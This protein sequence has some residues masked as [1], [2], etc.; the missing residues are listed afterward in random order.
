MKDTFK[1]INK[2]SEEILFKD[3]NSKFFG[4]AFPV[5]SEDKV[6]QYIEDLK[7]QHHQARHWCYAYQIGTDETNIQFRA[8]DDG[9]PN[10][11]AG[12]P[13]YGQ[14]QSFEVT[15]ILIVVVRYFGGVKLGVSGLI[16]AYKTAAQL[17]L[18]ASKI[19]TKTINR[20]YKI[21]FDYKNMNKVMRIIKEK[22]IKVLDQK[23]ELDCQL[24]ISVRLK[25]SES[26]FNAF[27]SLFEVSI[28]PLND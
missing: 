9:E 8:N 20:H 16:N 2:P 24:N 13:I 3:K 19:V 21:T 10:N 1:T 27:D 22:N 28:S 6:K 18:E 23:L 11:S 5:S 12:M 4:Y 17:S 25:E 7:K 26:I 15:N 14:I